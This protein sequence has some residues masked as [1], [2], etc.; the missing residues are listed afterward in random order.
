MPEERKLSVG[1]T[2]M[3]TENGTSSPKK[4]PMNKGKLALAQVT[5]L[6]GSIKDF[7]IEVRFYTIFILFFVL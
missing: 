6:D 3:A 1:L 7:N 5:L 4:S 2:E